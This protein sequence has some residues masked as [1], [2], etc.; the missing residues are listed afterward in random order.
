VTTRPSPHRRRDRRA[1][2]PYDTLESRLDRII[3]RS[4]EMIAEKARELVRRHNN[5]ARKPKRAS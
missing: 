2:A 3:E 1:I 5:D 4:T